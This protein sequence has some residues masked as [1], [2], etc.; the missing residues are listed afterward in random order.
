MAVAVA[1]PDQPDTM[2]RRC[3]R[4]VGPWAAPQTKTADG[5]IHETKRRAVYRSVII[6][7]FS[8]ME[9]ANLRLE[10]QGDLD[11]IVMKGARMVWDLLAV[12]GGGVVIT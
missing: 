10:L 7:G 8:P 6:S 5:W 9:P 1:S 4:I 3:E 2:H 11:W 12:R